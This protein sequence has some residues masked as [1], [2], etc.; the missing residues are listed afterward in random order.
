MRARLEV[1]NHRGTLVP[2]TLG[3]WLGAAATVSTVIVAATRIDGSV[4]RAGWVALAATL[5]VLAAGLVDDL[6]PP[7]PRGV[8]NHLGALAS[9][10][11]STGIVKA[12]VIVAAAV[13]SIAVQPGRSGWIRLAGAISNTYG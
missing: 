8:R 12:I 7:G 13:V 4:G 9:G 2:R 1:E 6:A 3:L 10:Q 5:L 11:V